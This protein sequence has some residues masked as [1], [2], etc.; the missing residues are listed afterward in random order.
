M[1]NLIKEKHM[2]WNTKYYIQALV[3]INLSLQ[4]DKCNNKIRPK[5]ILSSSLKPYQVVIKTSIGATR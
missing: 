3:Y 4:F 5:F 2:K 1:I